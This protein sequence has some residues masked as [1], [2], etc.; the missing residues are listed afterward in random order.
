MTSTDERMRLLRLIE[1][2]Q[3]TAE[4]GARLMG[5]IDGLGRQP[6]PHKAQWVRVRITDLRSQRQ[7][8]NVH[9]PVGLMA[10]GIKLGARLAT[11]RGRGVDIDALL[12]SIRS[13]A[14]GK[15]ADIEDIEDGERLEVFVE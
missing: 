5:A 1:N 8:V 15:L 12:E 3:L 9:I 2:G 13:G 10:I 6:R 14:I 7:K 4:E 11:S